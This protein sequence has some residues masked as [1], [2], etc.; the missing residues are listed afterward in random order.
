[1]P[2]WMMLPS[3]FMILRKVNENVFSAL[4]FAA[5]VRVQRHGNHYETLTFVL[6][7]VSEGYPQVRGGQLLKR[8][9]E[10]EREH[11]MTIT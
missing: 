6:C 4:F 8:N 11:H 7:H 9:G 3:S 5:G 10:L 2:S 1:M